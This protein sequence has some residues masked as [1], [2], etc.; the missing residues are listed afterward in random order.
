[1]KLSL[2]LPLLFTVA[3]TACIKQS[4]GSKI[5]CDIHAGYCSKIIAEDNI[6]VI[7]DCNPKPVKSMSELLFSV[8]L[9]EKDKPITDARVEID[10]TMP[11]MFMGDNR[12]LLVHKEN[13]RYEGKGVIV[14][15]P[16]GKRIWKADV[17][18]ERPLKKTVR[19]SYVFEVK[20]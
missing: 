8:S 10:L 4:E 3:L 19:T 15:C 16:S 18:I 17:I 9:K 5:D 20:N 7:F 14:R 13:G 6:N 2:L 12:I 1:M 11:G